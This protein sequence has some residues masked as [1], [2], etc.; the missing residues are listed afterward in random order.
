MRVLC[1]CCACAVT[2]LYQVM[3][4]HSPALRTLD[5][6]TK[7]AAAAKQAAGRAAAA[8]RKGRTSTS[9]DG[10]DAVVSKRARAK[11]PVVCTGAPVPAAPKTPP[12]PT[13]DLKVG[14]AGG[15]AGGCVL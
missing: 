15:G 11:P 12:M 9:G 1:V 10:T 4:A 7:Q 5:E 3:P 13:A 8:K 14:G 6:V 2:A